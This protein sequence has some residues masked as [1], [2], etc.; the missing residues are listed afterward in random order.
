MDD[1]SPIPLT[2]DPPVPTAMARPAR[3]DREIPPAELRQL[4]RERSQA[5]R[6]RRFSDAD[7]LRAR[8]EA[9][10]WS[11]MDRGTEA[12][13]VRTHPLDVVE[14]DGGVRHG[15]T[16]AVPL[17][18]DGA[19]SDVTLVVRARP[20]IAV[21]AS[22][23]ARLESVAGPDGR[24][25]LVVAGDD[26]SVPGD[27]TAREVRIRGDVGPA[28]LMA[29]ARR[30]I[31]GGILVIADVWP[32]D[33]TGVDVDRLVAALDDPLVAVTGLVGRTSRDLRRFDEAPPATPVEAVG[34]P[35]LACRVEDARR[36]DDLDER[37][38]D[39]EIFAAWW[40][41]RLR[42]A[43]PDGSHRHRQAVG[44]RPPGDSVM[45]EDQATRKDRYR[46]LDTFGGRLDL[47]VEHGGHT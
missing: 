35:G 16:G 41:L 25:V 36:I 1:D 17:A 47:L 6:E 15:W 13:L 10:G 37:F 22:L 45:R 4:A 43:G 20:E 38:A 42:D 19:S 33:A 29:V 39:P 23:L 34:W 3:P 32:A 5:R 21:T 12:R 8:I 18:T 27:T 30:A 26:R 2:P 7:E 40:S 14:T 24:R 46:L 28:T 31:G 9:E 44:I 11:V